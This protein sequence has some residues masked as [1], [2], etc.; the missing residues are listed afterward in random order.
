[1]LGPVD[2]LE[3]SCTTASYAAGGSLFSQSCF[4]GA[5]ALSLVPGVV[6]VVCD[7]QVLDVRIGYWVACF[8]RSLLPMGLCSAV[9]C[10]LL[11]VG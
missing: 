11:S 6:L 3:T 9:A 7:E 5:R 1:M 4:L 10:L 2:I 8:P